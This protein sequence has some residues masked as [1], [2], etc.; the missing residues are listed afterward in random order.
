IRMQAHSGDSGTFIRSMA[1]R[2][3]LG[4]LARATDDAITL[5]DAAGFDKI[6]V[7]TVGAGQSEVEIAN[8]AQT[9][10]VIEVPGMGDDIQAIKAGVLEIADLFVVN[11]ADREGADATIRQLRAMLHMGAAKAGWS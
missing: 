2:G 3:R 9:T 5:L 8:T 4:G 7:E 11:K 6:I 1:N 10:V